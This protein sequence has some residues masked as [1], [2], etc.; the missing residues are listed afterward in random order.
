[1]FGMKQVPP[2]PTDPRLLRSVALDHAQ[3]HVGG[4]QQVVAEPGMIRAANVDHEHFI[5]REL[6][7]NHPS[8]LRAHLGEVWPTVRV[9]HLASLGGE[10]EKCACMR[11]CDAARSNQSDTVT[12]VHVLSREGAGLPPPPN[13]PTNSLHTTTPQ[14]G[15]A[16]TS[17]VATLKGVASFTHAAAIAA[18]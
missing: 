14:A 11:A 12:R 4:M 9:L 18:R 2:L 17:Q 3:P 16:R 13:Q 6:L 1:M 7:R 15:T 5:V 8:E 10:Y